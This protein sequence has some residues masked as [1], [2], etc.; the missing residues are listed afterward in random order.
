MIIVFWEP[1]A[2]LWTVH[3]VFVTWTCNKCTVLVASIL[4]CHQGARIPLPGP[5]PAPPY[6][7]WLWWQWTQGSPCSFS[8]PFFFYHFLPFLSII[9]FFIDLYHHVPAIA[10]SNWQM[11]LHHWL[12]EKM[13]GASSSELEA[14]VE[15]ERW[16]R[17]ASRDRQSRWLL[18]GEK[19]SQLAEM[20]ILFDLWGWLQFNSQL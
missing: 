18:A 4:W 15:G 2:E 11:R 20:C 9:F 1:S 17:L 14:K 12:Y 10:M 6:K 3:K 5:W 7:R 8:F 16:Y 13:G 19:I